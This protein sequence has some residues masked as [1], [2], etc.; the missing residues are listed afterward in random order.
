MALLV[1]L[2]HIDVILVSCYVRPYSGKPS[3]LWLGW[4]AHA[5]RTYSGCPVLVGGDFSTPH[6]TWGYLCSSAWDSVVLDTFTEAEF[7]HLNS[8]GTTTCRWDCPR[9]PPSSSDMAIWCGAVPVS[10]GQ[11]SDCRGS[12]HPP[13]VISLDPDSQHRCQCCFQVTEWSLFWTALNDPLPI[14]P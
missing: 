1:R 4:I 8:S 7:V 14:A 9:S 3:C 6:L 13:L 2:P 10:G 12:D 11:E 5:C